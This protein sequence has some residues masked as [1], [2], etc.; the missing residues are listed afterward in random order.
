MQNAHI[1]HTSHVTCL[2]VVE[3]LIHFSFAEL[4]WNILFHGGA[5]IKE[6]KRHTHHRTCALSIESN[7]DLIELCLIW[8][9]AAAPAMQLHR[10]IEE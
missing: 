9:M 8:A 4:N 3:I 10:Y 7:I 2:T 5:K 1:T 6:E